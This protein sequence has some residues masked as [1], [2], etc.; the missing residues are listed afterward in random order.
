MSEG[1]VIGGKKREKRAI[2]KNLGFLKES[3]E[4]LGEQG[5][6]GVLSGGEYQ[7]LRVEAMKD[8]V[9]LGVK[10]IVIQGI[11]ELTDQKRLDI[12]ESLEQFQVVKIIK[13]GD[14]I[15]VLQC[16]IKGVTEIIVHYP[17]EMV[18]KGLAINFEW[19]KFENYE[20]EKSTDN[21]TPNTPN[22]PNKIL[23]KLWGV[24][25]KHL[26]LKNEQCATIFEPI[27]KECQCFACKEHNIAYI[28]HL[29]KCREMTG[30]VLLA[31]HNAF[32]YQKFIA[33][34]NLAIEKNEIRRFVNYFV[35]NNCI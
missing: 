24:K 3:I 29:I 34:L 19:K 11:E 22:D 12:L 16:V 30:N 7:E 15:K 28:N 20:E 17:W 35:D 21:N 2:I 33:E 18:Q 13:G 27:S 9:A 32:Q 1:L 26:D 10:K 6:V 4:L 5:V 14:P 23:Y 31:V 8:I 25:G